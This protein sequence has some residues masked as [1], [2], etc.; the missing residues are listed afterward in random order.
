MIPLI[1][2]VGLAQETRKG[3]RVTFFVGY[4]ML[5]WEVTLDKEADISATIL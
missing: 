3:F 1:Y 2:Q 4:Q 5:Y